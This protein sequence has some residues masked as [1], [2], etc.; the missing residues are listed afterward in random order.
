MVNQTQIFTVTL[1]SKLFLQ[2]WLNQSASLRFILYSR[3]NACIILTICILPC[4]LLFSQ[5]QL[6]IMT[7]LPFHIW[8]QTTENIR[9]CE[10]ASVQYMGCGCG[11]FTECTLRN[12]RRIFISC[13]KSDDEY[14]DEWD[15]P[16]QVWC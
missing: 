12:Q 1:R 11:A 9:A 10:L 13:L 16:A 4:T 2:A 8:T 7:H 15:S 3:G 5:E 14:D 6:V